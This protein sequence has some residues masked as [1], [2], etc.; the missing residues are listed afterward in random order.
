MTHPQRMAIVLAPF[1]PVAFSTAGGNLLENDGFEKWVGTDQVKPHVAR[2]ETAQHVRLVPANRWPW[3]WQIGS[4]TQEKDAQRTGEIALDE[5]VKHSGKRSVRIT[6]RSMTDI[7]I[8]QYSPESFLSRSALKVKPNRRYVIRWWVKGK[9]IHDR[10]TGPILMLYYISAKDGKQH[11]TDSYESTPLPHGTFDW[12][13]REFAFVT[14]AH[15]VT[16]TFSLQ[17]R[18]TTGTVWYDDVELLEREPVVRVETY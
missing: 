4:H 12:Q 2:S 16:M 8:V 13:S 10:G 17:L 15:A 3:L 9:D 7:T 5:I 18:W 1:L 11:R 14:D 6:N